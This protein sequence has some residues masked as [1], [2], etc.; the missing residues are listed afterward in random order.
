MAS[1]SDT[2]GILVDCGNFLFCLL[3]DLP[4]LWGVNL[5]CAMDIQKGYNVKPG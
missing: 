3:I 2:K 1:I 5:V 4:R